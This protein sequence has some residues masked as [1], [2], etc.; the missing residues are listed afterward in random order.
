MIVLALPVK[1][2]PTPLPL[3]VVEIFILV[4]LAQLSRCRAESIS[5]PVGPRVS[6]TSLLSPSRVFFSLMLCVETFSVKRYSLVSL[7]AVVEGVAT[8]AAQY[9]TS[10]KRSARTALPRGT[11][12]TCRCGFCVLSQHLSLLCETL[13]TLQRPVR[14]CSCSG[15]VVSGLGWGLGWGLGLRFGFDLGLLFGFGLALAL[16]C[17]SWVYLCFG[18][19][20][21]FGS[22]LGFGF[23]SAWAPAWI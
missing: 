8:K 11:R 9:K 19:G 6:G 2:K 4:M 22:G 1:A 20:F 23:G 13:V 14:L 12:H 21:D 15:C 16:A 18:F 3:L 17:L 7:V 5:R 10:T